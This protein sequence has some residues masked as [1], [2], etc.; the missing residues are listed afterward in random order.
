MGELMS[1]TCINPRGAHIRHTVWVLFRLTFAFVV[2]PLRTTLVLIIIKAT[3][4]DILAK[5]VVLSSN[6]NVSFGIKR[7][8]GRIKCALCSFNVR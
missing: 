2:S 8:V 7:L 1:E 6:N 4:G 3:L 5:K